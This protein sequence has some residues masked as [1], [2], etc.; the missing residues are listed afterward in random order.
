MQAAYGRLPLGFE[1]NQGQADSSIRFLS[2]S[3]HSSLL[4]RT[5]EAEL[6]LPAQ[7]P[8]F[9]RE[10]QPPPVPPGGRTNRSADQALPSVTSLRLLLLGANPAAE[11]HGE[12]LL[13]RKSHY[14]KGSDPRRWHTDVP[15]Y[16]R[17]RYK[18]VYPGIDLVFYGNLQSLEYDFIVA[19]GAAPEVIALRFEGLRHNA[20]RPAL[21]IDNGDLLIQTAAGEIRQHRAAVFQEIA[22]IRREVP[23]RYVVQGRN[24]VRFQMGAFDPSEPLVIDPVLSYSLTGVG[25]SAIA[26]DS[27]GQAYVAGVANPSFIPSPSAPQTTPGG[28][29]CVSGPNTVPCSDI[30]IAKLNSAGTDLIYSTFLGGSG[31]DYA[32]G[33]AVDSSGSAYVTGAT[34]STNLP[35]TQGALQPSHS[36]ATCGAIS[37]TAPCNNAFVAKLNA[38]GTSLLYSTYLNGESGGIGGNSIAVD[39]TGQAHITGDRLSGGFVT[40]LN[41]AGTAVLYSAS[42]VG[43]SAIALD[44]AGSAYVT[45]RRG[46]DSFVSKLRPDSGAVLYSFRLGGTFTSFSAPPE[47]VEALTGVAVDSA[48]N[49]YVTGYTAYKDFPTT[50]GVPFPAPLGVG[51]CGNSLCRD[52]FISKLNPSGTALVYSTFLGGDSI[53]YGAGIAVD[54]ASNVYVTGVTRSSNFPLQPGGGARGGVFVTKINA[55][56]TALSFSTTLG[57]GQTA[58][59]GT[60]IAVDGTGNIYVTGSAGLNF[61]VTSGAYQPATGSNGGFVARLFDDLTLFVP[62]ILSSPGQNGSFF[63]SELTLSNRSMRDV[64]LEFNYTAAFGGGSGKAADT[65]PAGRQRILPDAIAYLRSLGLPIPDSGS[66]GG[67]LAARFSGLGSASEGAV[68]VRTATPVPQGRV[69]LAYPGIVR[70]LTAPSYLFGLRHDA[71][72]RSNVAIQNA[73]S[74]TEGDITLR[75]TVFSGQPSFP[76]VS[77]TLPEETLTPGEFRQLSGILR[78]NG[79]GFSNGFVRVE[80]V[81]GTAPYYAYAVINDQASS[82]GSFISPVPDSISGSGSGSTVPVVVES[83]VFNTELVL[84]NWSPGNK[85]VRLTFTADGVQSP[86]SS[87]SVSLILRSQEQ[88][89][90]PNII[91]WMRSLGAPGLSTDQAWVGALS[92][93]ITEGEAGSVYAGA[94]TSARSSTGQFGVAYAA[95]PNGSATTQSAWIYGLQQNVENRSNLGLVNT[96]E[97]D[98]SSVGFRLELFDGESGQKVSTL[99]G[100]SVGAKRLLQIGS[101]FEKYAPATRQG[102]VHVIRIA[103]ANP[104]IAYSV[105]NDGASPGERTGDGAFISSSP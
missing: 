77:Q 46:T 8:S 16:G 36:R 37:P 30:L 53:D 25:G 60:G 9:G 26:V 86:D 5:G 43:G 20:R 21:S 80:R 49:A 99:E 61:P 52:A 7:P 101:L 29:T 47:E 48:G 79:L 89:I 51:I 12:E 44:T 78:S 40:K 31:S 33:I 66:R 81:R 94:R 65:L 42:A 41:A 19:P 13:C 91:Q 3:T 62:V 104:F 85:V 82:D 6:R 1:A 97:I 72:D 98:G 4:F 57:S 96:G 39:T 84:A 100:I 88:M 2:H 10:N 28:G 102:Y 56:G 55:T 59:T 71:L 68:T 69:G 54:P 70:G 34:S 67:T 92:V 22:G 50:P 73:G 87:T 90:L 24:I 15:S 27:Q 14:L 32:Y 105:I 93:M 58:E 35:V 76:A 11:I 38:S 83:S 95:V 64:T 75:L 103:G 45:G 17:I 23:S 74:P 63:T 18:S